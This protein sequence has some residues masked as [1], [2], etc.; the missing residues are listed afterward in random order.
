METG[1]R[2]WEE[3]SD[4]ADCRER[5]FL[6][7]LPVAGLEHSSRKMA[8]YSA[9]T[10]MSQ[11]LFQELQCPCTGG[12]EHL[13]DWGGTHLVRALRESDNENMGRGSRCA[14]NRLQ[15]VGTLDTLCR[16]VVRQISC[17]ADR[18]GAKTR[19]GVHQEE[20]HPR[21]SLCFGE[22]AVLQLV[23]DRMVALGYPR[24]VIRVQREKLESFVTLGKPLKR[25][26]W[27]EDMA[28]PGLLNRKATN[29][30]SRQPTKM[31]TGL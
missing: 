30:L 26:R 11:A 21:G 27:C 9:T 2:I 24:E 28:R 1:W 31:E 8:N 19:G 20:H 18:A 25:G 4:Q 6:L 23:E 14:G 15:N 12:W 17:G 3:L 13:G 10:G 5:D 7:T 16:L 22:N 29:R